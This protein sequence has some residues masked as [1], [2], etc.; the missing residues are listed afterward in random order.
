MSQLSLET[1]EL[2][3]TPRGST[4]LLQMIF[5]AGFLP[6]SGLLDSC[7]LF[8]KRSNEIP[9]CSVENTVYYKTN[10]HVIF[11]GREWTVV[12]GVPGPFYMLG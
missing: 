5:L 8:Q 12:K 3:R 9:D 1:A 4:W 10:G 6:S 11:N 2:W 7:D